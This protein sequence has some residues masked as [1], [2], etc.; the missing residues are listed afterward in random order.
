MLLAG[1]MSII[2]TCFYGMRLIQNAQSI[3]SWL[4][5]SN[6][7]LLTGYLYY[8]GIAIILIYVIVTFFLL[9]KSKVS[10]FLIVFT[11][12][13]LVYSMKN[14]FDQYSYL[15]NLFDQFKSQARLLDLY[16]TYNDLVLSLVICATT[17]Y[18]ALL[19]FYIQR[20]LRNQLDTI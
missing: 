8:A 9:P 13:F 15:L 4:N 20:K 3:Y 19:F 10:L 17:F 14:A 12:P 2:P 6:D 11:V 5:S 7:P 1:L 16:S 18:F